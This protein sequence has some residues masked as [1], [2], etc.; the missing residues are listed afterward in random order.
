[1]ARPRRYAWTVLLAFPLLAA[2]S[3][4]AQEAL[5]SAL[6]TDAIIT[7]EN[8]PAAAPA[9]GEHYLGPVNFT[10]STSLGI[11]SDDNSNLTQNHPKGDMILNGGMG[12]D[13]SWAA[14]EK[15][16]LRFGSEFKYATYLAH[17]RNDT[18]DISPDSALTWSFQFEDGSLTLYDQFNYSEEVV[19]VASVGG[20]AS[21]P[22]FDNTIGGRGQWTPGKWTFELGLSHSDFRSTDKAFDYLDSGSEYLFA[23]GA[24]NFSQNTESGIELSASQTA[25]SAKFQS[26]NKSYSLGPYATWKV[27]EIINASLRGGPT[28]YQFDRVGL[29]QP[30]K[31]LTSYYLAFDISHELTQFISHH[32][33]A[34][35]DVNLGLNRGND[36]NQQF[37]VG[38][39]ISWK[40]TQ[41][42]I[43]SANTSY[44]SGS[45]PLTTLSS[46]TTEHYDQIGFGAGVS[47]QFTSQLSGNIGYS[48][49][50]RTSNI[51]SSSYEANTVS[52]QMN[53]HF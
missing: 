47:Y 45:Q 53:Y 14:T 26:D 6:S 41:N 51:A 5:T 17:T 1:M 52:F 30:A 39:D 13:L 50:K 40:A 33:W 37:S 49:Y 28:I 31:T 4:Q 18:L 23:R 22:R 46:A 8:A 43:F 34:K 9:P 15:S 42:A 3:M 25:Y 7:A 2:S 32:L 20:V 19:T 48:Y 12:L 16:E 11:A 38:Y 27:A 24:W 35:R 10:L 44:I 29:L 36:F 21:L